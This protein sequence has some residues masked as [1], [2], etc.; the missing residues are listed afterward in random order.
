MTGSS[1][2]EDRSDV[3]DET[4]VRRLAPGPGRWLKWKLR[5]LSLSH[6]VRQYRFQLARSNS[7]IDDAPGALYFESATAIDPAQQAL[8]LEVEAIVKCAIEEYIEDGMESGTASQVRRFVSRSSVPGVR[9]LAARVTSI[10][11][12][13]AVAADVVRILGRILHGGTHRERVW[14]A[15]RLL[16]S[17]SPLAR[18][19]SAVA[20][21]E[22]GDPDAIAALQDAIAVESIPGLRA[23][24]ETS[25]QE[26]KKNADGL[27]SS[28]T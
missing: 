18:D 5:N 4:H 1:S 15:E 21:E 6:A 28:E 12:N 19:A 10:H 9:R 25:L 26:L 23:D 8:D 13:A 2:F 27:H 3:F 11:A 17:E 7:L 14:I 24:M 22:L 16:Q 20:L